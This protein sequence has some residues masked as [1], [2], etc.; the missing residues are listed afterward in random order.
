[1]TE[2]TIVPA[3]VNPLYADKFKFIINEARNVEFFCFRVNLPGISQNPIS[4]PTPVNPHYVG[5]KKLYYEDLELS[6]RVNEDLA[7]Y[8]E[9]FNWMVGITGPQST[10]QF[11]NFNT[12]RQSV[13]IANKYEIWSDG[14]LF[15]LTNSSNPNIIINFKNLQPISLSGLQMDS[16]DFQT[17]V[18]SVGFRYDWY[19]FG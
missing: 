13:T 3:N 2:H 15:S 10:D 16:T 8:K 17:V 12:N 6:F 4:I 9:I 18:A 11:K 7:N 5:G 14:T 1:M 19:E